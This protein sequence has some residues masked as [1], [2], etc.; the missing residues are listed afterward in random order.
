MSFFFLPIPGT[1]SFAEPFA[2]STER[3]FPPYKVLPH[4]TDCYAGKT[5]HKSRCGALMNAVMILS[6][7]VYRHEF[8]PKSMQVPQQPDEARLVCA[9]G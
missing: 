4:Q 9:D 3:I 6:F 8:E 5:D 2:D 7:T 1:I